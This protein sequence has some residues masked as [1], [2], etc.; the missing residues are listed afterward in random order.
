MSEIKNILY[1]N[2]VEEIFRLVVPEGDFSGT[3]DINKPDGWDEIDSVININED[4]FN[5]EDFIIGESEKM[6]FYEYDNPIIFNLIKNIWKRYQGDGQIIF[7]W[8]AKKDGVEIDLLGE[9]FEIN[10]NK[11]SESYEKTKGKLELEIKKR[12][13][14]SKFLNREDTTINLFD[15]KNIDQNDIEPVETF[16]VGFKKGDRTLSNF[17][18]YYLG[19][20][21][22]PMSASDTNIK[23]P[24]FQRSSDY[25]FGTN[26][27]ESAGLIN[28][29]RDYKDFPFVT[30]NIQLKNVKV[31]IS[32]MDISLNG[33]AANA[34]LYAVIKNGGS[35][36]TRKLLKEPEIISGETKI[37]IDNETF[38]IE[39]GL[40]QNQSL[41]LYIISNSNFKLLANNTNTTIEITTDLTSP[42]VRTEAVRIK[43]ALNKLSQNY[44]DGSLSVESTILSVGGFYYDTSVSTGVYLRGLPQIYTVSQKI[45]TSF[46][47]LFYDGVAPLLSLGFDINDNNV[48]VEDIGYFFK[49]IQSHDMRNKTFREDDYKLE[50]DK[51]LSVNQLYFGSKKYSTQTKFDIQNFNTKLEATTPIITSK[52]KFDKQT[53]LIIDEF[54]IQEL[55]E[56]TSSATNDSDDDMVLIDM[57][58]VIDSWDEAVFENCYH[59]VKD[60]YL[61][62]SCYVTPFDTT[63]I[64][65]GSLVTIVEGINN[66]TYTVLSISG[67]NII[68]NKTSGI[69]TGTYDTPLRY[70]ISTLFK[71]RTGIEGEGFTNV[72]NVKENYTASNLRHNPKF[73]MARWFPYFGSGLTTKDNDK[74]I[75]INSYKNNDDVELEVN[76]PDMANELQGLIRVGDNVPLSQFREQYETFFNGQIIEITLVD[77]MFH[78]FLDLYKDWKFGK[79]NDRTKSRGFITVNTPE[80]I[81]NVYPF[82]KGAL[83]HNKS[84]NELTIKGK[85][86]GIFVENPVLLSVTQLNRNTVKLIWD[87]SDKYVNPSIQIQY[88]L[89]EVNWTTLQN[90]TNIKETE[91]SNEIFNDLMTG[92]NVYFR[93][94]VDTEEFHNKNSNIISKI[95]QYNDY[96]IRETYL[97]YSSCGDMSAT[98][99]IRGIIDFSIDWNINSIPGG[100]S[101]LVTNSSD[102]SI[103]T[104]LTTEYGIYDDSSSTT[105]HTVDGILSI[106]INLKLT[107]KNETGKNLSCTSGT[108]ISSVGAYLSLIFKNTSEEVINEMDYTASFE[109]RYFDRPSPDA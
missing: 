36:I 6:T 65:V 94:R 43:D 73:H 32:N 108:E 62:L 45:K 91:F 33:D 11:Y 7:K 82:G 63:F 12:E 66:G 101:V 41:H 30:T 56:D 37:Y 22:T 48:I 88:S 80:G 95:W 81:L 3:Y 98:V 24:L 79:N 104:S 25:D 54:K 35:E 84:D 92:D 15:T 23:F 76:S 59:D 26:D 106:N 93:V 86:K 18:T 61:Q 38:N 49:N 78:E 46:K 19:D 10:L 97:N 1:E 21:Q 31:E 9:N 71:N 99:E 68:L 107:S 105:S 89:N 57:V 20:I 2:G 17:Y 4:Y 64:E 103:I 13:A 47:S 44:T 28:F 52:D 34:K 42:L 102:D 16:T 5:V 55:I 109:K 39:N 67:S 29:S 8:L 50:H 72:N 27:N 69:S 14:Q 87:Y 60:E 74:E 75:V 83:S 70:K 96:V 51:S 40:G 53:D 77:V 85:V 100:S 58:N 90:V